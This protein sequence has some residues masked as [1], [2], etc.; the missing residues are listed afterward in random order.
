[1]RPEL[2]E[3]TM[4][5]F[6]S[7]QYD[8]L[9]CTAIIE[10]GLDISRANTMF[11]D[12]A[13]LFGLAQLYQLR[14]RIGRSPERAYCY[15]LVPNL[16]ELDSEARTR[17]ETIERFTELGMGMRVAA[18]DMEQR[19]AGDLLGAEQSGFVTSVGFEL[20]CHLLEDATNEARGKVVVHEV[21]PDLTVDVEALIPEDYVADVGLRLAYYKQLAA[22]VSAS[23]IDETAVEMEDRFGKPPAAARDLIALM[24]L[25]TTLRQLKVLGCDAR[26]TAVSLSL[27][28][29]TPIQIDCLEQLEHRTPGAYRVTPDSRL[30]R[31]ARP[32]E[33][34]TNGIAHAE[35]ML[36]ELESCS[37]A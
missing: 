30:V 1:M 14:G 23:S 29:D 6:V 19:G 22:A 7:G 11:I 21:E 10:S 26:C 35:F 3:R 9:V 36:A 15:L 4:L 2:L 24:R 28:S 17:L 13:D 8:V 37:R 25:K 31:L 33:R 34:F 27:R 16:S 12:R 18:L 32:N 20:F 5:Q